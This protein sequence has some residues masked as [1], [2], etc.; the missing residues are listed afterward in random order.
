[1]RC[2]CGSGRLDDD[3]C[4]LLL[5]GARA[6]AT[7]EQLV[8]SRYTA[9]V[10]RDAAYLLATWHPS[11][12]PTR[13]E[14]DPRRSW[15]GLEVVS[16]TGRLL[17]DEGTVSFRAH[18]RDGRHDGVLAEDSAFVRVGGR[19]TYTGPVRPPPAQPASSAWKS[20]E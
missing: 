19:W 4:R 6:A 1:M 13:L 8:R 15:T 10:R 2:P 9:F 5:S 7:P 3:C 12:R 17:A 20:A 14:L 11:T 18:F 16:T